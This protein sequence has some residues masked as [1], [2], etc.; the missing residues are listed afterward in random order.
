MIWT[1][2]RVAHWQATGEHPEVAVWTATQTASFLN[3]ITSHWL[4]ALYHLVA[5]RGCGGVRLPGCAGATL[6]SI[7]GRW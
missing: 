7:T 4:Y 2:E 1:P 5:F 3:S 6:T